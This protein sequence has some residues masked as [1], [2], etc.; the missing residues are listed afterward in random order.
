VTTSSIAT[1][2][3][4]SLEITRQVL[5]R[6]RNRAVLP[7]LAAALRSD[8]AAVR[9]AAIRAT[10]ARVDVE[11]H[12]QLIGR[13]AAFGEAERA[14]LAEAHRAMPHHLTPALKAAVASSN[15]ALCD[16]ACQII[17]LCHHIDSVPALLKAVENPRHHN[18]TQLGLTVLQLATLLHDNLIH[19]TVD[20]EHSGHD[21]TF[22]R[23]QVLVALER[24]LGHVAHEAPAEILEAFILLAPSDH[25]ALNRIL[26]DSAH[27]YH[28]TLLKILSSSDRPAVFERLASLLRDT[29]AP[30][31]ALEA[32]AERTDRPFVE[33][34]LQ[35]LRH[36]VPLRALHNMKR[37]RTAAW[38]ESHREMLLDLDG[39][40]QAV[41][42]ELAAASALEQEAYFGLLVLLVR[43]GLAEGRR[44]ACQALA[45][46]DSPQA[47]MLILAALDDP[48]A[49][50]Q[51]AA[52]RQLRP[53]RLPDALRVLVSF[54]DSPSLEVREAA[55]SSLAEFN[56]VRYRAM[57]DLLDE[58][59]IK[60]TGQL[61]HKVDD[62][63][64]DGL[65]EELTS[66]SVTSRLRGIEMAVAM[67]ATQ[68]VCS[69]LVELAKHENP[70]VRKEALAVL[71][72]CTGPQ[73]LAVL[74]LAATDH[75]HS[76]AETAQRSLAHH[77][78][79][80]SSSADVHNV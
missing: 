60:T 63:A 66:P 30:I 48:D 57:F 11:S 2:N 14:I 61:V 24:F 71:A 46:F 26:S 67:Q 75:N 74:E 64:I 53:R 8:S 32:I 23:H 43:E 5:G 17:L 36:P 7:V 22:S 51:A 40:A 38:L 20:G 21:P 1:T 13:F 33:F 62:K 12:T 25:A 59:A 79:A 15:R 34:L 39:R 29:D 58:H 70:S 44:A 18:P 3:L 10:V 77:R 47:D 80:A 28:V 50:V 37:L 56:F 68:E 52:V 27:V 45:K 19:W 42:I 16:N 54:L 49:A 9:A 73:V 31:A 4:N 6:S 78:R 55:R 69:Q 41:A 76:I 72:H 35:T 65:L